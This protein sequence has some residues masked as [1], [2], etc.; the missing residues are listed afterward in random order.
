M[1]VMSPVILAR[2]N[3]AC[4]DRS[5]RAARMAES[6]L[7]LIHPWADVYL[8]QFTT[9]HISTTGLPVPIH[10][11]DQLQAVFLEYREASKVPGD[12]WTYFSPT[13][14]MQPIRQDDLDAY[15]QRMIEVYASWDGRW[16]ADV[17]AA[18]A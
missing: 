2:E 3:G 14:S 17:A 13:G 8:V 7:V 11:Q 6:V 16:R 10:V 18:L 12:P 9:D 5:L 4:M 1:N 15:L